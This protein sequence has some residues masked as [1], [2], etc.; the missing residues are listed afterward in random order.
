MG[1]FM[2]EQ[3]EAVGAKREETARGRTRQAVAGS[4]S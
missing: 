3:M 2:L 1:R 4:N